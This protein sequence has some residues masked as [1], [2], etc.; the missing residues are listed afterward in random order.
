MQRESI[1]GNFFD[2]V[3]QSI[4]FKVG[5]IIK[6]EIIDDNFSQVIVNLKI[7]ENGF[8][9]CKIYDCCWK[10]DYNKVN[11]GVNQKVNFWIVGNSIVKIKEA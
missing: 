10:M 8:L 5:K 7:K 3:K 2:K 1:Q 9:K 11:F 6:C 4:F